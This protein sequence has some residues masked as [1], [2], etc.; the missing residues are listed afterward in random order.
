[1]RLSVSS[2]VLFYYIMFLD[3][4]RISQIKRKRNETMNLQFMESFRFFFLLYALIWS[5]GERRRYL[6][7]P[8]LG[9]HM[10]DRKEEELRR[11]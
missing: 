7:F 10:W 9:S 2:K 11:N 3:K 5:R 6:G 8:D 4:C 1:M